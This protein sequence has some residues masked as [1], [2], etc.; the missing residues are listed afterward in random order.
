MLFALEVK[1]PWRNGL[2][3]WM[4][5]SVVGGSSHRVGIFPFIG[6]TQILSLYSLFIFFSNYL[7]KYPS[8][9][10]PFFSNTNLPYRLLRSSAKPVKK[11]ILYCLLGF[12][13]NNNFSLDREA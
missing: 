5:Y 13:R 4:S 12:H 11:N 1:P 2:A 9:P 7:A 8:V 3:W 10:V 6:N